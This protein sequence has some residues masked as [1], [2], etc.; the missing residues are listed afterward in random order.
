MRRTV[1]KSNRDS[2]CCDARQ[3]LSLLRCGTGTVLVPDRY[4]HVRHGPWRTRA[5]HATIARVLDD[6]PAP[7]ESAARLALR[8]TARCARTLDDLE[9]RLVLLARGERAS[10]R[11][12]GSDLGV[13]AATAHRRHAGADPVTARV[14]AARAADPWLAE[15]RE[16][17]ALARAA[18]PRRDAREP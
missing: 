15:L 6:F 4:G 16:I 17:R 13:S 3:G 8:E 10:W 7:R 18:V 11:E 5:A 12:I 14:R 2:P 1:S 9:R